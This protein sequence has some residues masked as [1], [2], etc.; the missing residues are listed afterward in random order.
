MKKQNKTY[1][2]KLLKDKKFKDKFKKE[3]FKLDKEEK[4]IENALM[5]GE[6][7]KVSDKKLQEIKKAIDAKKRENK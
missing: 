2:D 6:Y 1:M 7:V 3:V 4:E 5:R